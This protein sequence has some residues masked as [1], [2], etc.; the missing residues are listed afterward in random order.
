MNKVL[1]K[2][3]V[4]NTE[5]KFSGFNSGYLQFN[6]ITPGVIIPKNTNIHVNKN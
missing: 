4:D 1:D 5:N 2:D 6:Q 3:F